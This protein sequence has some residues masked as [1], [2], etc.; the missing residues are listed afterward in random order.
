MTVYKTAYD[1]TACSGFVMRKTIEAVQVAAI[2]GQLPRVE[3]TEQ[4]LSVQGGSSVSDAIP[5]FGHPMLFDNSSK[6]PTLVVDLRA[7]GRFDPNQHTFQIR[8]DTEYKLAS[9]RAKLNHIWITE[10][11][12]ILRDISN[13]PI[14]VF[15]SWISEAVAKR[16]AL[17]PREQ[18]SLSILAAMYYQSL[19]TTDVEV[20]END[21]VRQ[22][23]SIT[24]NLRASA[25]DVIE[26]MDKVSALSGISS[27]C[28]YAHVVTGSV[29]LQELNVGVLYSILGGTWYGT[30]A[31]ENVAVALEHPPTWLAILMAAYTERSFKNSGITKLTERSGNK[32]SGKDFLRSTLN[33]IA[34]TVG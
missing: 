29:R 5:A 19:F 8:N 34:V 1:T 32:D 4:I 23:A 7:F 33:L 17:D 31:K 28:H 22:L 25:Q 14:T 9:L 20:D 15:A 30:N 10:R 12:T 13:L 21:K 26:V 6:Q 18:L 3:G 27:F 11:P 24:R 16:F 2:D